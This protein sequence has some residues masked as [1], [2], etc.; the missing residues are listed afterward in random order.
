[1]AGALFKQE[2]G[3][4]DDDDPNDG[5]DRLDDFELARALGGVL[6]TY[7]P[8]GDGVVA[9]DSNPNHL[10]YTAPVGGYMPDI[11]TAATDGSIQDPQVLSDL[12]KEYIGGVEPNRYDLTA[13]YGI[14]F[15][16]KRGAFWVANR[17]AD[18]FREWLDYTDLGSIYKDDPGATSFWDYKDYYSGSAV[19]SPLTNGYNG[20]LHSNYSNESTLIQQLDDTIAR[21]VMEDTDVLKNLLTT[22]QWHAA[23]N[24][25]NVDLEHTCNT[26][27]DCT[28]KSGYIN[29]IK[30]L[31][32]CGS[33]TASQFDSHRIYNR[34]ESIPRTPEGRWITLPDN[35]RAGVLTHPAWLAAHG[36]NFEDDP[37]IIHRGK[38]IRENM[39]CEPVPG[40]EL[41]QV[42]AQV[43]PSAPD[44][45]A[46][47]RVFEATESDE[48]AGQCMGCHAKMNSLGYPFEIY[49]HAGFVRFED[50]GKPPNGVSNI[51][52][53]PDPAL[54]GEVQDAVEFSIKLSQSNHV[55]RCFIRQA[56]RYVMARNETMNDA[57]ALSTMES[58]YDEKGSFIDMIVALVQS[59]TFLYRHHAEDQP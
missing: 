19:Y 42:E 20:A 8:G 7:P 56:F 54:N 47:D 11:V 5:R 22:R 46:R 53:A 21:V 15:R 26:D 17:L 16:E 36:G 1:M 14:E 32:M 49:N 52:N 50:H 48:K 9:Y 27:A 12:I 41:V 34:T 23:S 51:T 6:S 37:S 35:E 59:H 38:W 29:C 24:L 18:F 40:L 44:K 13:E 30:T 31:K 3:T 55:K 33:N 45:T 10:G 43:G 58:A 4:P 39:F 25:T 57:C 28:V 2:L